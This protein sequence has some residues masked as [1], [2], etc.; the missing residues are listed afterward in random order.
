MLLMEGPSSCFVA[1]DYCGSSA[2]DCESVK[3]K[4]SLGAKGK[5][6]SRNG[7]IRFIG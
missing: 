2:T 5:D 4:Q 6:G 7:I 3:K 1:K